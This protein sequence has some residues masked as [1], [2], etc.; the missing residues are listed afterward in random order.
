LRDAS[1]HNGTHRVAMT[2]FKF[3]GSGISYRTGM[4]DILQGQHCDEDRIISEIAALGDPVRRTV[5]QGGYGSDDLSQS[6][7]R[8]FSEL[9]QFPD[10]KTLAAI[11]LL[12]E[13]ANA[14][15][16]HDLWNSFCGL[17]R[18]MIPD[19]IF[20]DQV[21]FHEEVFDAID[22]Y[23]KIRTF[24]KLNER[25]DTF[26][27]WTEELPRYQTMVGNLKK[28]EKLCFERLPKEF[29]G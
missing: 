16:N 8:M 6:I 5:L 24:P 12:L 10:F 26:R 18:H 23:A 15:Q 4:W 20:R 22:R 29:R 28:A 21:P 19:F 1:P 7:D 11:V 3:P 13:W 9:G 17:Y 25:I 2:D 27:R 14:L